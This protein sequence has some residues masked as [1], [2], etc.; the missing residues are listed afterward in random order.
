MLSEG[1]AEGFIQGKLGLHEFAL[2]K[3]IDQAA[4]FNFTRLKAFYHR[5][6]EAD[7][8]I[9]TS[10]YE[11]DLAVSILVAEGCIS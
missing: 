3:T 4:R 6:L 1:R 8:T 9:K 10:R 2:R 5:L 11:E 7:V